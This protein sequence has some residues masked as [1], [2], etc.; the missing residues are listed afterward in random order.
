MKTC[1][2]TINDVHTIYSA[3]CAGEKEH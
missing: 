2:M 1:I 3:T